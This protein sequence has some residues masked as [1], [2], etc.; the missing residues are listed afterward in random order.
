MSEDVE[1]W[2]RDLKHVVFGLLKVSTKC[3]SHPENLGI[4]EGEVESVY[5]GQLLSFGEP[6]GW[7]WV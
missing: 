2:V 6:D 1:M 4:E 5:D 3:S 7:R